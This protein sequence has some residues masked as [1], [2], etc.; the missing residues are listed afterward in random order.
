MK[1]R[2]VGLFAAVFLCGCASVGDAIV[3][4]LPSRDHDD[5]K[6]APEHDQGAKALRPESGRSLL[7]VILDTRKNK[8]GSLDTWLEDYEV[9]RLFEQEY[10]YIPFDAGGHV[11]T[12]QG[13]RVDWDTPTTVFS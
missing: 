13:S 7:F 11:L 3:A 2:M 1:L 4:A 12:L 8:C 9:G 5:F 10:V 6:V